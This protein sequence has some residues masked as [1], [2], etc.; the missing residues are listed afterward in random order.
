MECD[1]YVYDI[2]Y[3]CS[4]YPTEEYSRLFASKNASS[5]YNELAFNIFYPYTKYTRIT[6]V[7]KV[8]LYDLFS[9][10]GGSMGIFVG[11]TIFSLIDFLE[12]F[13]KI[14]LVYLRWIKNGMKYMNMKIEKEFFF[15]WQ[16]VSYF[17][18]IKILINVFLWTK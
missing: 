10:L 13:L 1:S 5:K 7:P 16:I 9:N 3:S 4:D 11:F 17:K 14:V 6:E 15:K 12:V 2:E 18:L 8:T